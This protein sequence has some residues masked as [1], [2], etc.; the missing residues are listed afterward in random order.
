MQPFYSYPSSSLI[1]MD[2]DDISAKFY[3]A[4]KAS[5]QIR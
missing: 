1:Y 2:F 4:E 3:M 5:Q